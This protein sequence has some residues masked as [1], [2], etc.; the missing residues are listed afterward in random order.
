MRIFNYLAIN[1]IRSLHLNGH[2]NISE[3]LVTPS[4]LLYIQVSVIKA[5]IGNMT[6]LLQQVIINV[7]ANELKLITNKRATVEQFYRI[8]GPTTFAELFAIPSIPNPS[9]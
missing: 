6:H 1:F 2:K 4:N 8:S 3:T 5:Q 9:I 7:H